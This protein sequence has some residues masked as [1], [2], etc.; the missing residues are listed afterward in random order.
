MI[1][2]VFRHGVVYPTDPVPSEWREG[3]EV[4]VQETSDAL[5]DV[6]R[7]LCAEWKAD[8]CFSSSM[9]DIAVHPA[10]QRIIGMGY[11]AVGLILDDLRDEPHWWFWALRA[12]TG[13]DPVHPSAKGR[14]REMARAWLQW[15]QERGLV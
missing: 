6:F 5:R 13:E 2:A 7:R 10:Y 8:T 3:Q 12:I 4:R 9:A 15:G 14:I 1:K 11:E